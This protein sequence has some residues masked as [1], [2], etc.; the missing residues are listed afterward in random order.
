M[1]EYG[2][3]TTVGDT[4]TRNNIWSAIE[5][6]AFL[7]S[8]ERNSDLVQMSAYQTMLSK[9][10]AQTSDTSAVWFSSNDVIYTPDYYMQ[11]MFANNMGTNYISS[12][13]NMEEDGIYHSITV[14]AEQKVIYVKIAN[15]TRKTQENQHQH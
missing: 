2:V 9:I 4:L 5:N 15:N 7:M 3:N 11:M 14:D 10:N 13:F 1:S 12:D 8:L 6:A